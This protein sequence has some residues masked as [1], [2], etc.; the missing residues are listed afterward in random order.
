F[1][2]KNITFEK[3]IDYFRY[4]SRNGQFRTQMWDKIFKRKIIDDNKLCFRKIPI[5]EDCD[6]LLRYLFYVN[7]IYSVE[8]IAYIYN[9]TNNTSLTKTCNDNE[10][11]ILDFLP[12]LMKMYED[13]L[14]KKVIFQILQRFIISAFI[15]KYAR[16]YFFSTVAK[17]QIKKILNDVSIDHIIRY[18]RKHGMKIRDRILAFILAGN[19]LIYIFI[20]NIIYFFK[21]NK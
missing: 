17:K 10:L 21:R 13:T 12:E 15:N 2:L 20:I 6:F 8:N 16:I 9:L 7:K 4:V 11:V 19:S 3:R 1:K 18:N 5:G 14:E